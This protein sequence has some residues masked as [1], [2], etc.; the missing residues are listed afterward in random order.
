MTSEGR[1]TTT[2][3]AGSRRRLG[4]TGQAALVLGATLLLGVACGGE[5]E[6]EKTL[7]SGEL[8]GKFAAQ[9]GGTED[10]VAFGLAVAADGG[11]VLAGRSDSLPGGPNR[12]WL[13]RADAFGRFLWGLD[14]GAT[15]GGADVAAL[16]GGD[17]VVAHGA[18]QLARVDDQGKVVWQH[19]FDDI[20]TKAHEAF[21]L[22]TLKSGATLVAGTKYVA[23][24]ATTASREAVLLKVADNGEKLWHQTY[25]K[26]ALTQPQDVVALS[27]GVLLAGWTEGKV[28]ATGRDAWVARTDSDGNTTWSERFGGQFDEEARA[29][30]PM[31]DGAFLIAGMTR[32]YGAGNSDLWLLKVSG[33]GKEVWHKP[34][35]GDD[36]DEGFGLARAGAHFI[37]TGRRNSLGLGPGGLWLLEVDAE[38]APVWQQTY[39]AAWKSQGYAVQALPDGYV[40]AGATTRKS[41]G[42]ND[43]WLVRADREGQ[44]KCPGALCFGDDDLSCGALT[45]DAEADPPVCAEPKS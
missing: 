7:C 34:Y 31:G 36:S 45:C 16:P 40:V 35:G 14:L 41:K 39:G 22:A 5:P 30:V 13:A 24:G 29:A 37:V 2:P 18:L 23:E 1:S 3:R 6:P 21:A 4:R 28:G 19:G 12:G 33:A 20:G 44:H 25:A 38:G 27:K 11:F 43:F 9:L 17:W 32:S 42:G 8:A 26:D 10:E 15:A